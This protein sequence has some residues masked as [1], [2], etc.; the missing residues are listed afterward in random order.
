ML[1][2]Q[3]GMPPQIVLVVL[4]GQEEALERWNQRKWSAHRDRVLLSD[5]L[6][7]LMTLVQ[8]EL[9]EQQRE[10]LTAHLSIR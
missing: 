5:H 6:F 10:I 9:T 2:A 7:S 8:A 1:A 4:V 3:Q